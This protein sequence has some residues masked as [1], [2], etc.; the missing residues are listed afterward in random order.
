M[1]KDWVVTYEVLNSGETLSMGVY[2]VPD[3]SVARKEAVYSLSAFSDDWYKIL[4][5]EE[6]TWLGP[7]GTNAFLQ[8]IIENKNC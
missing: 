5:I 7:E 4:N 1:S 8:R 2:D 6:D 3:E